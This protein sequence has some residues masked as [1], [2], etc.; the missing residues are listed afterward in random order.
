MTKKCFGI[1]Y[2]WL[3]PRM[4]DEKVTEMMPWFRGK[5]SK[6]RALHLN[7]FAY[8]PDGDELLEGQP[9]SAELLDHQPGVA[10]LLQNQP[11]PTD[12]LQNISF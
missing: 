12:L 4:N 3:N 9:S 10:D 6:P 1:L 7:G 5:P 11:T 2:R 8:K